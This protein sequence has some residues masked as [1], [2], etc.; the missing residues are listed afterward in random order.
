M[1]KHI[2]HN[3][4]TGRIVVEQA[5]DDFFQDQEVFKVSAWIGSER[6]GLRGFVFPKWAL[7]QKIAEAEKILIIKLESWQDPE[8]NEVRELL[9]KLGFENVYLDSKPRQVKNKNIRL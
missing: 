7:E 3:G 8:D 4:K 9:H 6:V 5:V 2:V 1:E